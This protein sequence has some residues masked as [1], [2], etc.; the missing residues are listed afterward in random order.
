VN[1]RW[2]L[3]FVAFTIS[4]LALATSLDYWSLRIVVGLV[5]AGG[6]TAALI[7]HR[8]RS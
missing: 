3:S 8:E 5:W 7:V 2:A 6:L 1:A 4:A